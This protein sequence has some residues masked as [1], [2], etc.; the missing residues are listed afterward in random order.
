MLVLYKIAI[1]LKPPTSLLQFVETIVPF[2]GL[3][4]IARSIKAS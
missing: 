3:A 2:G 4:A 1:I